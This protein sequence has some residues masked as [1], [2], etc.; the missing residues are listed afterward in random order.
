MGVF[1][2][3]HGR[4]NA[5]EFADE[6][7]AAARTRH[8]TAARAFLRRLAQDRAADPSALHAVLKDLRTGF[9][10]Q[11][12]PAGASGQVRSVAG[13]FALVAAAG[14]LAREYDVL[15]WPEGEAMR[16]A[17][18]CFT[19]W[20]NDRGGS[21]AGEDAAALAQV[22]RFLEAH[23]ER[24]FTLLVRNEQG[25]EAALEGVRT[26]NRV[27]F[28]R[29]RAGDVGWEYLIFPEGWKNEVCRGIDARR[30][31]DLLAARNLLL[32]S[33]EG[34]PAAVVTIPG[35]SKRRM[36]RISDA[37]LGDDPTGASDGSG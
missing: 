10:E 14:E 27:G 35:E 16:A 22:R 32:G 18:A 12:V 11:H 28:R 24:R 37:I 7:R 1:Q 29:R 34:H 21:G 9:M 15:P 3:L 13:R 20:L 26:I 19:A 5:A 2:D 25:N 33:K 4:R 17:A 8:G 23:G 36:Y 30:T 6:L 31:A